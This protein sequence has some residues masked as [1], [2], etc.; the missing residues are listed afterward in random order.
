MVWSL[1]LW[2]WVLVAANH[3]HVLSLVSRKVIRTVCTASKE[4]TCGV[5]L[6]RMDGGAFI[7]IIQRCHVQMLQSI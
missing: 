4:L 3:C 2:F 5:V 1:W 7:C 6:A